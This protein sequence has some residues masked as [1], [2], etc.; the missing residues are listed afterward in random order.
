MCL[1][2]RQTRLFLCGRR[3][4]EKESIGK[5]REQVFK[6]ISS[7]L[8]L[9]KKRVCG[10][11]PAGFKSCIAEQLSGCTSSA[12]HLLSTLRGEG[13]DVGNVCCVFL[14]CDCQEPIA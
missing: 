12:S 3:I 14:S 6:N 9:C 1:L 5:S 4:K 10:T 7:R 13:K 8:E 11:N 2:T